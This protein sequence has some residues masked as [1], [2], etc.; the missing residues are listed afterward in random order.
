MKQ[1][2]E[3]FQILKA[4]THIIAAA[5]RVR[6]KEYVSNVPEAAG[7]DGA[8]KPLTSL[9][10]GDFSIDK[11]DVPAEKRVQ[12]RRPCLITVLARNFKMMAIGRV[13]VD[14]IK[15]DTSRFQTRHVKARESDK[16]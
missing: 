11:F 14:R 13:E 7:K 10:V 3:C 5:E 15:M 1:A 9:Q 8:K 6:C 16:L 4:E 2:L 12:N